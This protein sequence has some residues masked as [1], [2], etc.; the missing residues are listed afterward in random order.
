MFSVRLFHEVPPP[1]PELA[2][3]YSTKVE[4]KWLNTNTTVDITEIYNGITDMGSQDM[5][6]EGQEVKVI[7]DYKESQYIT[8]TQ[9]KLNI[10]IVFLLQSEE[11]NLI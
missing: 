7:Y 10:Y 6:I 4:W 1:P 11:T 5:Y 8:Y 9:R 3:S 2:K